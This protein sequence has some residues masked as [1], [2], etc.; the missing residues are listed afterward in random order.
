MCVI[1][2]TTVGMLEIGKMKPDRIIVG[3]S[4]DN[5]ATWKATCWVCA[6]VEISSPCACAPTR[7]RP[8]D[9]H[10]SAHEPRIGRSNSSIAARI[11]VIAETNEITR[12]GS[13]LPRMY[14]SGLSGAI[15]TCS[16]VPRSFSRTTDS[17][18]DTTAVI[19]EM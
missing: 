15:R 3:S 9:R 4:D 5:S 18:V 2:C 11:T 1:H 14:G 17:A 12:Y 8:I 10:N 19:I 13:V 7:N 16:M 6:M